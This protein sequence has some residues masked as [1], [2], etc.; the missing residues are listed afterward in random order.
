MCVVH[1][2]NLQKGKITNRVRVPE[3]LV[4]SN[5]WHDHKCMQNALQHQG[6]SRTNQ[7]HSWIHL[8]ES[9]PSNAW[10]TKVDRVKLI[11]SVNVCKVY[12]SYNGVVVLVHFQ[13][14]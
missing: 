9:R 13:I 8:L 3:E 10:H 1:W 14:Y 12:H 5:Q 2:R 6:C 7:S 11:K 4:W